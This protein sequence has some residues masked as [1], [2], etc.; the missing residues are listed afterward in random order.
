MDISKFVAELLFD[1]ECVV[2]PGLGGFIVNDRPATINR[3]NHQFKPPFRTIL[4]NRHVKA[5]DGLLVNQMATS[6]GISFGKA[7]TEINRFVEATIEQ[8]ENGKTVTFGKIGSLCFDNQ[9]NFIFE[10]DMSVNYN[11]NAYGLTGFVSPPVKRVTDE[12]KLR[13]LIIPKRPDK[14]KP[15]DRKPKVLTVEKET[16]KRKTY[17]TVV[18]VASLVIIVFGFVWGFTNQPIVNQYWTETTFAMRQL[19]PELKI[20]DKQNVINEARYIPRKLIES[21]K[22]ILEEIKHSE[23]LAGNDDLTKPVVAEAEPEVNPS[24]DNK[25]VEVEEIPVGV[26]EKE[27]TGP[28][29]YII[30]GSFSNAENAGSL[31][32]ELKARGYDAIIADTN[33]SG[34]FRVAYTGIKALKLAR[35]KLY[36]IRQ[37]DNPE[38]WL[39]RK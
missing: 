12:E 17:L 3:I 19:Y 11:P 25:T 8:L 7:R 1:F 37:D 6:D 10:Q 15:V 38:A 27:V 9:K 13:N 28:L 34:M 31:V 21:D 4:F 30:A 14:T 33:S 23:N 26:P 24:V 39:L 35:E 16:R 5:N 22:E 20:S 32:S 29:Y 18:L 2:I 36:A